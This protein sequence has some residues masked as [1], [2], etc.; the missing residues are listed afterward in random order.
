M[1]E[2]AARAGSWRGGRGLG[3]ELRGQQHDGKTAE[4]AAWR[5]GCMAAARWEGCEGGSMEEGLQGGMEEGLQGGS[6]KGRLHGSRTMGGMR[7]WQHEA[8]AA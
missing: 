4:V 2:W 8:R 6:T 3:G 5:K 1:K 7:G